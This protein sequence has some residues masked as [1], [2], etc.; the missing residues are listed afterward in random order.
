[1]SSQFLRAMWSPILE[2]ARRLGIL[3][4][5]FDPIHY[6]HLL[7]AEEARAHLDLDAVLFIPTGEPPHKPHGRATAEQR[8]LM[9]ELATADHPAFHVSRLELDRPGRS[10]TVD[11]LRILRERCPATELFL[12]LGGDA[13][14]DFPRWHQPDAIATL[15]RLVVATRP[16]FGLEQLAEVC[17]RYEPQGLVLLRIPELHLSSSDIRA[18]VQTG[19]SIQY[20]TRDS[21]VSYIE[22]EG[23]YRDEM[24]A[25]KAGHDAS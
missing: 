4:G 19:Q 6:G 7:I 8:Y 5:A 16:G 2:T 20:L 3:G 24:T 18:R 17:A 23:L 21:V 1:M 22:K 14:V 15:A 10:Y 25:G 11:T 13:A 9:T 12:L